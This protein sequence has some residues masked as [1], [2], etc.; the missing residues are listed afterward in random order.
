MDHRDKA[1]QG[2]EIAMDRMSKID[3]NSIILILAIIIF[4]IISF[5]IIGF[6]S[7]KF[8]SKYKYLE[9]EKFSR[10]KELSEKQYRILWEYSLKLDRDPFLSLEFKS[11]FEKIIDLYIKENQDFDE[12]LIKD[13]RRKL[14]FDYVPY[15]VPLTTTKDIDLFQGGVLKLQGGKVF[16]IA[17]YDK[18]EMF[19][20]WVITDDVVDIP[21]G[22][23]DSVKINFVRKGDAA[24]ILDANIE[25]IIRENG[26][27]IIKIPHTFELIRIQRR[28]YP[29][30]ETDL[31]CLVGKDIEGKTVFVEAKIVDIS[32]SGLRFCVPSEIRSSFD[33]RIGIN[34]YVQFEIL[35]KKILQKSEIVNIY[36]R[37]KTVCYGVK[38]IDIKEDV[39]RDIFNYV[40]K[41]QLNL[42]KLHSKQS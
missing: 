26:K 9:F 7:K 1:I 3:L 36:E 2:Y 14:G 33:I 10:E 23:S 41:Q 31:D 29:R 25:D 27:I 20:Y 40:K 11:P 19:L 13:M 18:D 42:A 35:N 22:I 4:L 38:F 21:A 34:V 16:R 8:R 17:L 32:P 28:E 5:L 12:N 15:F 30:V 39:Q 37:Q 6:L 24:Y